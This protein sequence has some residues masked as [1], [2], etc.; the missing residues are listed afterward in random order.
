[1]RK[2][3]SLA[4]ITLLTVL[5]L[6]LL[7]SGCA[8]P[9]V[10]AITDERSFGN[11]LSDSQLE[12]SV[13]AAIV[14]DQTSKIMSIN[15]YSFYGDIYLIGEADQQTASKAAASA[16]GV[17][18]VRSIATYFFPPGT[19][20]AQDLITEARVN[21][22]LLLAS[23]VP[24]GQV[25]VDVWAGQ[26]ILLGLMANQEQMDR[27]LEVTRDVPGVKSIKNYLR[28]NAHVAPQ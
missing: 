13:K 22:N 12:A 6:T 9:V 21:E 3:F 20:T 14:S 8:T 23:G 1:M 18:G 11:H 26:A 19:M 5:F 7:L 15:V 10:G 25:Q 2:T 27:V 4:P 16:R 17:E 24:S 28:I